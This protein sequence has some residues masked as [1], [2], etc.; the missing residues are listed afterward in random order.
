VDNS[1]EEEIVTPVQVTANG[2]NHSETVVVESNSTT[3]VTEIKSTTTFSRQDTYIV[4][5]EITETQQCN[6]QEIT[7]LE[8]CTASEEIKQTKPSI[9]SDEV[10]IKDNVTYTV[11]TEGHKEPEDE[12]MEDSDST[13]DENNTG[14]GT[15]VQDENVTT[16]P[17]NKIEDV[18]EVETEVETKIDPE[19][20]PEVETEAEPEVES[21]VEP[22]VETEVEPEVETEAEPEVETE[23]EPE[24]E[25]EV[26]TKVES[27][28][29]R[30]A[31]PEVE[32]QV[33]AAEVILSSSGLHR[34]NTYTVN[35][36]EMKE[37]S[38]EILQTELELERFTETQQLVEYKY[39]REEQED[40]LYKE[41]DEVVMKGSEVMEEVEVKKVV[42]D[43]YV[44]AEEVRS[45]KHQRALATT[46]VTEIN[47][48]GEPV[49]LEETSLASLAS[50]ANLKPGED[51]KDPG[52][53]LERTSRDVDQLLKDIRDPNL[54]C[55]LD[56]IEAMIEGKNVRDWKEETSRGSPEFAKAAALIDQ[57]PDPGFDPNDPAVKGLEDWDDS[58]N[59]TPSFET[60]EGKPSKLK[61][62]FKRMS[63]SEETRSLL[64]ESLNNNLEKH[65]EEEEENKVS[66]GCFGNTLLYI[67]LK[68]FD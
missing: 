20:D 33:E 53:G 30:E 25:T 24:V 23:V 54:D 28:V 36:Q 35:Q 17:E 50:L 8:N 5:Q 19:V 40:P 68:I 11:D 46:T 67:F 27:E 56:D 29:Q 59:L 55:S 31:E 48:R 60:E 61:N 57:N 63:R 6:G 44:T 64:N 15:L 10:E 52:D 38:A 62:V 22:E 4:D 58:N 37:S 21:E 41:P 49:I 39:D 16:E 42:E 47:S 32:P 43:Q 2:V 7:E 34:Q 45:Q 3:L 26:E 14:T 65:R 18:T 1:V 66:P 13:V 9:V 51:L 12:N